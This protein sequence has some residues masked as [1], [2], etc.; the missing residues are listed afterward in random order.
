MTR[1][2]TPLM[3][4][5]GNNRDGM[6]MIDTPEMCAICWNRLRLYLS[7]LTFLGAAFRNWGQV[8]ETKS[9]LGGYQ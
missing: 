2:Y 6:Y 9:I 7:R 8:I 1:T 5:G 3:D 4:L